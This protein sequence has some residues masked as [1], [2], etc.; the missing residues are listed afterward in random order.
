MVAT[1]K[2]INNGKS[3]IT[4]GRVWSLDAIASHLG[5]KA[6]GPCWPFLLSLCSDANRPSRCPSWGQA[7]HESATSPA[8]ALKLKP[9]KTFDLQELANGSQFCRH[10]TAQEKASVAANS[11]AAQPGQPQPG[12]P[13]QPIS[14][15][16]RGRGRDGR[17]RGRDGRGRSR[18][19]GGRLPG[20]T[21]TFDEDAVD[22][23]D[24]APFQAPS[25]A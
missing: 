6:K 23:D 13:I 24:E 15:R 18:G 11:L 2:F 16:G 19:R 8:H 3:L 20:L 22:D 5:V 12:Q 1:A 17:G 14:A 21:V 7:H 10:A 4:S 9:G 25:V